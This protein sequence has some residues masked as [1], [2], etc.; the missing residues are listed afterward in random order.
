[1]TLAHS[2]M[3]PAPVLVT[4]AA[5]HRALN[6]EPFDGEPGSAVHVEG[7]LGAEPERL[8]PAMTTREGITARVGG[9][10]G[11]LHDGGGVSVT[12]NASGRIRRCGPKV[13]VRT[14]WGSEGSHSVVEGR[15]SP[16]STGP[17]LTLVHTTPDG[18]DE[19]WDTC[20]SAQR[21][22][23]LLPP[24]A[25]PAVTLSPTPGILV[26]VRLP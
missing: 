16:T 12:D 10:G 20:R 18:R 4:A 21:P 15:L 19:H 1:M 14:D 23:S 13:A 24:G 9:V 17:A 8:W 6:H 2:T 5:G 26:T 25:C 11:E 22:R 3:S 7:E